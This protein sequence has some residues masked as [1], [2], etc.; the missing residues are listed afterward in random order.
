MSVINERG[1]ISLQSKVEYSL[2][3]IIKSPNEWQS[4]T[5]LE[6]TTTC[7]LACAFMESI[8]LTLVHFISHFHSHE[9]CNLVTIHNE[10]ATFDDK[11]I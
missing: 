5:E 7:N 11:N 8:N 4:I 2:K 1:I 10:Y 6:I 9:R 3:G